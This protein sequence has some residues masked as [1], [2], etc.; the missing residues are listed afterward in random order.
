MHTKNSI[1]GYSNGMAGN[2]R[3]AAVVRILKFI[4]KSFDPSKDQTPKKI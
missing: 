2:V 3:S 1:S 4:I